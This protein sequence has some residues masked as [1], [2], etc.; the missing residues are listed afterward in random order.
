MSPMLPANTYMIRH[1]TADDEQALHELAELDS[2]RP[3][4][5]PVLIGEIAGRPAAAIS[6][7]DG[8]SIADPFELTVHLCQ[9]LRMRAGAMDAHARTPSL[10]KRLRASV[11]TVPVARATQG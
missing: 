11:G 6:L 7:E 2:Q 10:P 4:N 1:A 9:V 8:R 3:L 5:G